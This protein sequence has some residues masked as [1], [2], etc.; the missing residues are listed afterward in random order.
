MGYFLSDR[1]EILFC[2]KA[3]FLCRISRDAYPAAIE[4]YKQGI[5]G[6]VMVGESLHDGEI[7]T[8][9]KG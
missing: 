1:S 5:S 3:K 8:E 2:M 6:P 4:A 9:N 7:G